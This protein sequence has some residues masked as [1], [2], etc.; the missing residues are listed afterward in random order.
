MFQAE[1][2]VYGIHLIYELSSIKQLF[3]SSS[4]L[5]KLRCIGIFSIS[6]TT[7]VGSDCKLAV[8]S[9]PTLSNLHSGE[10]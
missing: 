5:V 10:E 2:G 1:S 7:Y 3:T 4:I 6:S 8:P 9:E